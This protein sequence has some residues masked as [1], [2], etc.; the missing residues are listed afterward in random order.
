MVD[1]W[2]LQVALR[3]VD[4]E[5][6]MFDG[7]L[8]R[9]NRIDQIPGQ[10]CSMDGHVCEIWGINVAIKTSTSLFVIKTLRG[11]TYVARKK[12]KKGLLR[13]NVYVIPCEALKS[14]KIKDKHKIFWMFDLEIRSK[15]IDGGFF[16]R[17]LEGE[18]NGHKRFS[19]INCPLIAINDCK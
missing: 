15:K 5:E 17:F 18:I 6:E 16:T 13:E 8:L 11:G 7:D 9:N 12:G 19:K 10:T 2:K 4:H 1:V 3:S 14:E